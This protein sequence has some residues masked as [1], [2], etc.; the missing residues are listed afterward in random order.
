M[1]DAAK[2][3][4]KGKQRAARRLEAAGSRAGSAVRVI[5]ARVALLQQHRKAAQLATPSNSL[6][7]GLAGCA[8]GLCH[9]YMPLCPTCLQVL[10]PARSSFPPPRRGFL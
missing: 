7:G 10:Q 6:A 2:T 1:S 9:S 5:G 3:P 4:H 8:R